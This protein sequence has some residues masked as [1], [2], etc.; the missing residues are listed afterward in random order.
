MTRQYGIDI[1]MSSSALF[2]DF[3]VCQTGMGSKVH[4]AS[5]PKLGKM[6]EEVVYTLFS[7]LHKYK[8]QWL[9]NDAEIMWQNEA[10]SVERYGLEKMTEP[11][12]L[13]IDIVKLKQDYRTEYETYHDLV[14][15]YLDIYAYRE[16]HQMQLMDFYHVDIMLW[17]Q[18]VYR[19]FYLFGGVSEKEKK[20]IIDA[21]KPLYFARSITFDY[22][23]F[24]YTV[25]FAEEEVRNQALAFLCQKPYLFGLHGK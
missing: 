9:T 19:L 25:D 5:A 20:E 1:F 7:T 12:S 24:R 14:K 22:E 2:G 3:K 18:M 23:T 21:L 17:S 11:Q 13:D 16:I 8:S 15:K 6:F 4:N 10:W